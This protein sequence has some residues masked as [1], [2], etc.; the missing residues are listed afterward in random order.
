MKR[1]RGES[2]VSVSA[3]RM[4]P[5]TYK[6]LPAEAQDMVSIIPRGVAGFTQDR[7]T[8]RKRPSEVW[9]MF[10]SDIYEPMYED[11]N[12]NPVVMRAEL[13]AANI[14]APFEYGVRPP[15]QGAHVFRF[16]AS[17][18]PISMS[19]KADRVLTLQGMNRMLLAM[20]IKYAQDMNPAQMRHAI[21]GTEGLRYL[22]H[23][24]ATGSTDMVNDFAL[25]HVSSLSMPQAAAIFNSG[26]GMQG[27][28]STRK[29]ST[30][31]VAIG[32]RLMHTPD[33]WCGVGSPGE[34]LGFSLVMLYVSPRGGRHWRGTGSAEREQVKEWIC[35]EFNLGMDGNVEL[36]ATLEQAMN[37]ASA[38][39]GAVGL[40]ASLRTLVGRA[41]APA[42]AAGAAP[43]YVANVL[44]RIAAHIQ[45]ESQVAPIVIPVLVP[46]TGDDS[47]SSLCQ[48]FGV[49]ADSPMGASGVLKRAVPVQFLPAGRKLSNRTRALERAS[50]G[51]HTIY[52]ST[53]LNPSSGMTMTVDICRR[54]ADRG[55]GYIA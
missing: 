49:D 53:A 50:A 8:D 20:G 14:P 42:P 48:R 28:G 34:M 7:A 24:M 4:N 16:G 18:I 43:A 6:E 31:S 45:A 17:A 36:D 21:L 10:G 2:Y 3:A 51:G 11:D 52:S 29:P 35:K 38:R 47:S 13:V 44:D 5:G 15:G 22:G 46:S 54:R 37:A 55:V 33:V 27:Y 1:Q 30:T 9:N 19:R 32:D 12:N 23:I 39:P 41:P 26:F 25:G 40:V